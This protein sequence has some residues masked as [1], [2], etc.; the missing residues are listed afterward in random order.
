MTH[1][2]LHRE[3]ATGTSP[4]LLLFVVCAI[5]AA[6]SAASE[7]NIAPF[8]A[9]TSKPYMG[10]SAAYLTDGRLASP[11]DGTLMR[12]A[13]LGPR[14]G[15]TSLR[16]DF[17]FPGRY[18]VKRIRLFQA[19]SFDRRASTEYLIEADTTGNGQ[20]DRVLASEKHGYGGRWFTYAVSPPIPAY[21]I[22][23][24]TLDSMA[25][26]GA[27]FGPPAIEEFEIYTDD[28]AHAVPRRPLPDAPRLAPDAARAVSLPIA[29]VPPREDA[30][31][32]GLF[33]SMWLWWAAGQPYSGAHNEDAMKL[34]RRLGVNRYWLYSGVYLSGAA[35][36][37]YVTLPKNPDYL[38]FVERQFEART[39]SA[40]GPTRILPFRSDVVPGYHDNVLGRLVAQMHENGI[41]VI[42]NELLLPYGVESSDF[43]R[44]VDLSIYP[45]VRSSTF[46]RD[47]STKLYGE[48]MRAGADGLSLGGDEFFLRE[49]DRADADRSPVCKDAHGAIRDICK[50]TTSELFRRRFR[51]A[52]DPFGPVF[53]SA[54]GKWTLFG[55]EQLATLFAGYAAMM[56]SVDSDAIVTSLFRPGQENRYR[57]GV[58]Y[59]VMGW[60]GG[61]TEMSSDPYWS[62]NSS[63]GHYYFAGEVK[64]LSGASAAHVAVVTLQASPTFD[65]NGYSDPLL[66]YGPAFSAMMHGARGVN[67]YKQ[68]YL[69]A[70]GRD[71]S[72]PWVEK[73]FTLTRLLDAL[74]LARYRIPKAVALLYSRASE[75]WWQLA[76]VND[77]EEAS[78]AILYQN[79]VMEALFRDG[80]PFDLHYLD[81]PASLHDLGD[82]RVL[83]LPYPY[84]ISQAAADAV[85][86]A[87]ARGTRVIAI[88]RSGEVDEFGDVRQVPALRDV[89]GVDHL[90][91]DLARSR[92]DD[93]S[94]LLSKRV[95]DALGSTAPLRFDAAGRDVE[96]SVMENDDDRL[97]FCLNWESQPLDVDVGVNV[98]DGRYEASIITMDREVPARIG[99]KSTLGASDLAQFRLALGPEEAAVIVVRRV[100]A[101]TAS[102]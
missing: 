27:N 56:K 69:F 66:L 85:R 23:F 100:P 71:D 44:V 41:S 78:Q 29:D 86:A 26:V 45:S 55:Y 19:D 98:P 80:I 14:I 6:G 1:R 21:A 16:Y 87:I 60:E 38:H 54:M 84:S 32:R 22:R 12:A 59:D 17:A 10:A 91:I 43:P 5:V 94:S 75:D 81:Q 4:R 58:A 65:V 48:F 67:F 79:G 101:A 63:L 82:Y 36:A 25:D 74:G 9:I 92:Y 89:P 2:Q 99:D 77:P 83:V 18:A 52:G 20:Y 97:L 35:N 46:V 51:D 30:F 40:A 93:L 53:S 3:R 68:D 95:R 90:A 61:I 57:Y 70:G 72:G 37:A 13:P 15:V 11:D 64:K 24:R 34:L 88:A 33:G 28:K 7:T 73:F 76:H 96:C 39:G 8:C 49:S 50:P 47:A 62:H 42:A 31:R 102:R